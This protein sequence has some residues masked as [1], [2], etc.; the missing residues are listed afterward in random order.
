MRPL[1]QDETK[2][3]FEKLANY[4]GSDNIKRLLQRSEG[5]YVF[6]YHKDRVY[7]VS[8]ELMKRAASCA[9]ENLIS[10]GVCFGKFTKTKKFRLQIT[11]LDYLA[12]YAQYK[13]WVKP[14]SEQSFLYGNHVLKSGL[15]RITE[16][17]EQYQGVVVYSMSDV[18]LGFGVA[19][20]S[21]MDCRK[22]DPM[23]IVGFH[24]ADVG[25]YI[26]SEDTLI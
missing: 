18:P 7:Y 4:I 26:R 9:R 10:F 8:E 19:A 13:L 3:L 6:R 25:E 14:T 12:P 17:T 16:G 21:T 11:A 1:Q 15:G 5:N 2:A 24:Q 23:N 22:A 20:K